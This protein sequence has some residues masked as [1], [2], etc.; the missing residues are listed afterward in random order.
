ML[1]L[2]TRATFWVLRRLN[3]LVFFRLTKSLFNVLLCLFVCFFF[4]LGFYGH[5]WDMTVRINLLSC[6]L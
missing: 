4:F 6:V 2:K 1:E 3:F 5:R